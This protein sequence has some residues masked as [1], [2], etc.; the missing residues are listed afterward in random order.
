MG[1]PCNCR[2]G[3]TDIVAAG[4]LTI[5]PIEAVMVTVPPVPTARPGTIE[6]MPADTVARL[7]LLEVQ[8]A[9]SVTSGLP[10]QVTAVAVIGNVGSLVVTL[11]FVGFNVIAVMH[12]T[13]TVTVWVPVMDE[14]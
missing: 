10:L 7:V 3:V 5:L 14:F 2:Y 11:P 6:T 4:L 13:V 9:T 1:H 12:P 8:V